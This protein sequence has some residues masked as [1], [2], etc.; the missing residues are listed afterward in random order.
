MYNVRQI[1][2]K[3][4]TSQLQFTIQKGQ[5]KSVAKYQNLEVIGPYHKAHSCDV[6]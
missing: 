2:M 5:V 1:N 6:I 3:C 4:Y